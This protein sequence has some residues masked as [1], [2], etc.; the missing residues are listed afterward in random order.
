MD[1]EQLKLILEVVS[2]TGEGAK[3]I[4]LLYLGLGL[5]RIIM[6]PIALIIVGG[7]IIKIINI[8]SAHEVKKNA[9]C[10]RW[11][12]LCALLEQP[13]YASFELI[14]TVIVK[15]KEKGDNDGV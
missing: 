1:I 9:Y 14:R 5:V 6:L 12:K 15:L 8:V 2:N 4:A 13:N 10:I 3:L 7:F 11:E